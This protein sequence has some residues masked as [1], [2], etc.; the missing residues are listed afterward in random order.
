MYTVGRY[1]TVV[2]NYFPKSTV[3]L[4]HFFEVFSQGSS[5]ILTIKLQELDRCNAVIKNFGQ[6]LDF[7]VADLPTVYKRATSP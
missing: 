5:K 2:L 1:V 7:A 6:D 4:R 3:K